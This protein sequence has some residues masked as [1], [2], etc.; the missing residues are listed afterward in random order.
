MKFIVRFYYCVN[1]TFYN[2]LNEYYKYLTLLFNN[3]DPESPVNSL[4]LNLPYQPSGWHC[5]KQCRRRAHTLWAT[6][7]NTY[8][9][10]PVNGS[11]FDV[12]TKV[13]WLFDLSADKWIWDSSRLANRDSQWII[14]HWIIILYCIMFFVMVST[15]RR[16]KEIPRNSWMHVVTAEVREKGISNMEWIDREE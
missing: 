7:W 10:Q 11:I 13:N 3:L 6:T 14:A 12:L 8:I 15:W 9:S 5:Q 4:R 1:E 16:R 2:F